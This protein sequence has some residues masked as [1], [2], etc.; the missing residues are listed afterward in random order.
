M[1]LLVDI[2]NTRAKWAVLADG[3]LSRCGAVLHRGVPSAGWVPGLDAAGDHC[4]AILVSNVAGPAAAH[5]LGEAARA[6][7]I[8]DYSWAHVAERFE[9]IYNHVRGGPH[10]QVRP[11]T[12]S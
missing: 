10:L 3:R 1:K 11:T 9:E 7:T 2:G 4:E 6:R 8:R 12:P 5:A